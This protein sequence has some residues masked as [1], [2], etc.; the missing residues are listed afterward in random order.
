M[1]LTPLAL[2]LTPPPTPTHTTPRP[3]HWPFTYAEMEEGDFERIVDHILLTKYEVTNFA[4][5]WRFILVL[6]PSDKSPVSDITINIHILPTGIA[7]VFS[8]HTPA[9][10]SD[11]EF[12][13]E[14]GSY[15]DMEANGFIDF[16]VKQRP[17][18][19]ER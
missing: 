15:G 12:R 7:S 18:I 14:L 8:S 6:R 19:A 16:I 11:V 13:I 5:R 3:I 4:K 17:E 1:S 2:A 9:P 10:R